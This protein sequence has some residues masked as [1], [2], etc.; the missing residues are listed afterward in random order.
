MAEKS[1]IARPYAEAI[2]EVAQAS[3]KLKEWSELLQ[4][5]AQITVDE[6]MRGLIGNTSVNKKQLAQLIIDVASSGKKSV[7]TDQGSNLIRLL[8]ENRRLNVVAEITEQYEILKA[9]AEKTVEAEIVSAQEIS[10]KQQSLI[11]DKLKARLGR[12]V[13]L[14]CLVDDSLMGGAIIKAGDMVIDG[15]V[16]SKLNKLS[17]ELVG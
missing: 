13:S 15:S 11:A 10:A 16:S 5:I 4:T 1:T 3:N 17:V 6:D 12:E 14:R 9:E 2:F 8:T 7:M